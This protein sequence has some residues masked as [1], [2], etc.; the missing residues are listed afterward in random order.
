MS[1][2]SFLGPWCEEGEGEME[3]WES[4]PLCRESLAPP[5]GRS[6]RLSGILHPFVMFL[7]VIH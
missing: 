7:S 2:L 4:Y 5:V 1:W 3:K 6:R